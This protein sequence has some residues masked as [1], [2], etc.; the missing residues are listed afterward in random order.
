MRTN[1]GGW[2]APS[3]VIGRDQLIRRLWHTLEQQSLILSAERRTG[4]TTI[5]RKMEAE[6]PDSKRLIYRDLE[7]LRTP[8]EFV[9]NVLEDVSQHLSGKKRAAIRTQQFLKQMSGAEAKGFKLP[10]IVAPHWK[11]LLDKIAEDLAEHQDHTI[12]FLWDEMPMMLG[13]IKQDL[14]E[15][16]AMEVLDTL[17]AL[18]QTHSGLRMVYTGSIGLHHVLT[19]LKRAGYANAPINDMAQID[20]PPLSSEHAQELARRL[21]EG[22]NITVESPMDMAFAIAQ[23]VDCIPFYIH[24][25]VARIKWREGPV[26]AEAITQIVNACLTDPQNGWDMEHF[27][28]R[29]DNYY[30]SEE[31]PLALTM[32]DVLSCAEQPLGFDPL[33]KHPK[34]RI[35]LKDRERAREVLTLLQRDHYV[36]QGADG[37]Y[38]FRFPL[39]QRWWRLHRGLSS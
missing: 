25:V 12:I 3:D 9:E 35:K 2:I 10:T 20:V 29:M 37:A 21:L 27:R 30:S 11:S 36:V 7:G 31:C 28:T 32:L 14:G 39:I 5:V 16:A 23:A 19:S 6:A 13:N 15:K 24:H 22:E 18:R 34:S 33:F 38:R 8:I 17:R 1:P 4:K 26:N